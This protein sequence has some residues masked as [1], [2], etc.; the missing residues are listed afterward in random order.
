MEFCFENL[1]VDKGPLSFFEDNW[2]YKI[3]IDN[4]IEDNKTWNNIE[5]E[6]MNML[7]SI[8]LE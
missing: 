5:G 6:F 8:T 3:Y 7:Q 2:L 1:N 4:I